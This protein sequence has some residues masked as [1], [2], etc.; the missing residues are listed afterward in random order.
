[1]QVVITAIKGW[2]RQSREWPLLSYLP[3][4]CI[5]LNIISQWGSKAKPHYPWQGFS[6]TSSIL[7]KYTTV[8]RNVAQSDSSY[9]TFK[10]KALIPNFVS[11]SI[12]FFSN[13]S[14]KAC[15]KL[16]MLLKKKQFFLHTRI[17]WSTCQINSHSLQCRIRFSKEIHIHLTFFTD[18]K[19]NLYSLQLSFSCRLDVSAFGK[20]QLQY[21]WV[22]WMTALL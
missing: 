19:L 6:N 18:R 10:D 22:W 17:H 14:R 15:D 3:N 13:I 1:M 5:R 2:R 21:Q 8:Q 11:S 9:L 20:A 4:P 7:Q 12:F 16:L